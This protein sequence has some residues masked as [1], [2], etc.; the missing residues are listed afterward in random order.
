MFDDTS[1]ADVQESSNESSESVSLEQIEAE[2]A[3]EAAPAVQEQTP[4]EAVEAI[5]AEEPEAA[6]EESA[7][8][9]NDEVFYK[10]PTRKRIERLSRKF[11]DEESAKEAEARRADAAEERVKELEVAASSEPSEPLPDPSVTPLEE[12]FETQDE[13]LKELTKWEVSQ[14]LKEKDQALEAAQNEA[15]ARKNHHELMNSWEDQVR[16]ATET[17][18]D[19]E[20]V[21]T[22]RPNN[23]AIEAEIMDSPYGAEM[24]Y[25]YGT[26]R[27]EAE[28]V[29]AM[30]AYLAAREIHRLEHEFAA[31]A[32]LPAEASD[33][34]PT[35][36]KPAAPP[37]PARPPKPGRPLGASAPSV[38]K[39][40]G[41]MT[42]AEY[43][44]HREKARS[45]EEI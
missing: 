25:Y 35:E 29:F 34:E 21:V 31:V 26:N 5:P 12:D 45:S 36:T 7:S 28:R 2:A 42:P 20:E 44:K 38:T 19:F 8:K 40:F 9:Q 13:Y 3:V 39:T 18:P 1:V 11:R 32:P 37:K 17:H 16:V 33:R 24:A 43:Y 4:S 27:E 22:I 6:A 10:E 41:N 23:P 15:R 30:P 14:Q